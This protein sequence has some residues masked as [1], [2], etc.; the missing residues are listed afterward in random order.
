M[1]V[2]PGS[3]GRIGQPSR[4][5]LV[6]AID[7]TAEQIRAAIADITKYASGGFL[8]PGSA[9]ARI[10]ASARASV[11][12]VRKVDGTYEY[13]PHNL[14]LQTEDFSQSA[15][16][17]TNCTVSGDTITLSASA[18]FSQTST[19]MVAAGLSV[20]SRVE[21]TGTPGQTC[22]VYMQTGGGT[23]QADLKTIT[24]TAA[25]QE[26][27][28]SLTLSDAKSLVGLYIDNAGGTTAT[29][30]RVRRPRLCAGLTPTA[31]IPTTS[32]A[33]FAPA[34]THDGT[35]YRTQSEA[36]A[37]NRVLW[38][39][40]LSN[41]AWTKSSCTAAYTAT[42][43]DGVANSASTVTASGA[44]ATVLQSITHASTA[45]TLS[46][47]LKRRT[48]TGTVQ[49]TIDG[50]T[51]WVTRTLDSTWQRFETQATLANPSVGIRIVTSG[52]AVDVDFVQ[53]EDGSAATSPIATFSATATR[54]EE[55]PT[56]PLPASLIGMTEGAI[57]AD[58]VRDTTVP[59][60][61]YPGVFR[62]I[63]S[64]TDNMVGVYL[65]P[66]TA[67]RAGLVV[68]TGG[69]NQAV[70]ITTG[71]GAL[72]TITRVAAGFRVDDF[73]ASRSG[74]AVVVDTSGTVPPSLAT[75]QIGIMDAI[76]GAGTGITRIRLFT[77]KPSNAAIQG[78][79]A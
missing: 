12:M 52:D 76:F 2:R 48:G 13:A 47:F 25:W 41:A 6:P 60:G 54:A 78:L 7:A 21:V 10:N 39:R 79:A 33:V 59:A 63:A 38:C 43:I 46:M 57:V 62:L 45:R 49:T 26:V 20:S 34:I 36:S 18:N 19:A 24:L 14:F 66:T 8:L 53:P 4:S 3:V 40:D 28:V 27:N 58:Y 22:R 23:Y 69:A 67:T 35:Q 15:W 44:N 55:V 56:I 16:T 77:K 17:K 11:A 29:S 42:G 50:G 72:N 75:L 70:C 74:N 51:T 68:R 32:A 73:A 9:G 61:T 1:L 37:T 65:D 5:G 71:D 64:N 31:Y 30:V